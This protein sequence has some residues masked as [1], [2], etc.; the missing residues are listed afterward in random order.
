[1]DNHNQKQ[2][3][4]Q[5]RFTWSGNQSA[6]YQDTTTNHPNETSQFS[7]GS[8]TNTSGT[9]PTSLATFH[10]NQQ[11]T[12]TNNQQNNNQV[13]QY[14][15]PPSSFQ[16]SRA[17][18][19]AFGLHF[20]AQMRNF[21]HNFKSYTSQ[22][23]RSKKVPKLSFK[24][25]WVPTYELTQQKH[26]SGLINS[27]ITK[28]SLSCLESLNLVSVLEEPHS[29]SLNRLLER[30]Y[31]TVQEYHTGWPTFVPNHWH[32]CEL[33]TRSSQNIQTLKS[34]QS[35]NSW[36]NWQCN[37]SDVRANLVSPPTNNR[38]ITLLCINGHKNCYLEKLTW[39]IR[40]EVFKTLVSELAVFTWF[41]PDGLSK[42]LF[43]DYEE[44]PEWHPNQDSF[45]VGISHQQVNRD[46][47]KDSFMSPNPPS[48]IALCIQ[49]KYPNADVSAIIQD[50]EMMSLMFGDEKDYIWK[51]SLK[52]DCGESMIHQMFK[53]I[54]AH[55]TRYPRSLCPVTVNDHEA[56]DSP[57]ISAFWF[58]FREGNYQYLETG[59][60]FVKACK[61][62][63]KAD[64]Y[65]CMGKFVTQCGALNKVA[66]LAPIYQSLIL[67]KDEKLTEFVECLKTG[68]TAAFAFL[69][70]D[71]MDEDC[72]RFLCE[73]EEKSS[74]CKFPKCAPSAWDMVSGHRCWKKDLGF[75]VFDDYHISLDVNKLLDRCATKCEFRIALSDE[76][77]SLNLEEN[78][79]FIAG[80]KDSLFFCANKRDFLRKYVFRKDN[81]P[82]GSQF[83]TLPF[84]EENDATLHLKEAV[85]DM[86]NVSK[87]WIS[88]FSGY[89][90]LS[91]LVLSAEY[92]KEVTDFKVVTSE[93]RISFIIPGPD[94]GQ[95]ETTP[96][97]RMAKILRKRINR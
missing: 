28:E 44:D 79:R 20:G 43:N 62:L 21:S 69:F 42:K 52:D 30:G 49:K 51:V 95:S 25:L 47:A 31:G 77:W 19:G 8:G 37:V 92:E 59:L 97:K 36:T 12:A 94:N 29:V 85:S 17:R 63:Q 87:L 58:V 35:L 68:N 57:F 3:D 66:R 65:Y 76:L 32:L 84:K 48:E 45:S 13:V 50:Q 38:R 56:N 54:V 34:I 2:N 5:H 6:N 41:V 88:L 15:R 70:E 55:Y 7:W 11:R 74:E 82:I 1:M 96:S 80:M 86:R 81:V 90:D 89:P 23:Y 9:N 78:N 93:K 46:T 33:T 24:I 61:L 53:Q 26:K 4:P 75:F 60:C 16:S 27:N 71:M 14:Q 10:T 83:A 40:A 91:A 39:H 22:N 64:V 67:E 72:I 18:G 73:D